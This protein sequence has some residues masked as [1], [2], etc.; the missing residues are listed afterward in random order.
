[1]YYW[2]LRLC[3][4]TV[5]L[6]FISVHSI[7]NEPIFPFLSLC[8]F[9]SLLEIPRDSKALSIDLF[10]Y[11]P[12]ILHSDLPTDISGLQRRRLASLLSFVPDDN[13]VQNLRYA[14]TDHAS[15]SLVIGHEVQ[16]NPWEWAESIEPAVS[17]SKLTREKPEL[18]NNS[19]IPLELF[20]TRPT[21]ERVIGEL[22]ESR[23]REAAAARQ[24][25]DGLGSDSMFER[26]WRESRVDWKADLT[27]SG[28]YS[29]GS[30]GGN[31]ATATG[32]MDMTQG[33]GS[34]IGIPGSGGSSPSPTI[35]SHR[36][37]TGSTRTLHQQQQQ[38]QLGQ[39]QPSHRA[40][41]ILSTS[42][43]GRSS[44]HG[45]TSVMGSGTADSV[46]TTTA[47]TAG[48]KRKASPGSSMTDYAATATVRRGRPRGSGT[49]RGKTKKK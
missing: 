22:P 39:G 16:S 35:R 24:L 6:V 48:G 5:T 46:G 20:G 25:Q 21:G 32:G 11:T 47:P 2:T 12:N 8:F 37:S 38:H 4:L 44:V 42:S 3:Y 49:G 31:N 18:K 27:H 29:D 28:E 43:R 23:A 13:Y 1:M 30:G 40:G 19:S 26:D 45:D 34:Q 14:W 17:T 7:L 41:S 15:G 10:Q 36:S 9:I 33:S